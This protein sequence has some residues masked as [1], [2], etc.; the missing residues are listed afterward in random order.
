MDYTI[1]TRCDP[2]TI[3]IRIS[4]LKPC[5]LR[6]QVIDPQLAN[7]FL[8]N[9]L[10][11]TRAGESHDCFVPLPV[12]PYKSL[13]RIMADNPGYPDGDG[14]TVESITKMGLTTYKDAIDWT[15]KEVRQAIKLGYQFCYNAGWLPTTADDR[16]YCS[17]DASLRIKYLPVLLDPKTNKESVTPMRI[18]ETTSII[19]ASQSLCIPFTVAGRAVMYFHEFSHKYENKDP[20][21]ELEADLN[22]LTI[23]L[24][25]G[26]SRYEALQVY[27]TVFSRV[28]SEENT[29]RMVHIERFINNFEHLIKK[30]S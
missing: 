25:L 16:A 17:P 5:Q 9:R 28:P 19:E 8:A 27:Q 2:C 4:S 29:K 21:W 23:Y 15:N 14:Y 1:G 3:K 20:D 7:T 26:F 18:S 30:T 10:V 24:A 11:I 22:G 6:L 12:S 13:I